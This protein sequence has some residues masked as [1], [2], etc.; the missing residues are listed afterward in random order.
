MNTATDW[1]SMP[2]AGR[3]MDP[4][5]PDPSEIREYRELAYLDDWI[6]GELGASVTVWARADAVGSTVRPDQLA[7]ALDGVSARRVLVVAGP[8]DRLNVVPLEG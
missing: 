8:G 1:N 2:I 5:A 4:D 7:T 6:N 3:H